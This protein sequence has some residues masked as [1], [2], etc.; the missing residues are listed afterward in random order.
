MWS[1]YN[2]GNAEGRARSS[3]ERLPTQGSRMRVLRWLLMLCLMAQT[4]C[5]LCQPGFLDDYAAVGGKWQ[6]GNPTDGRLG[7]ILSAH[8]AGGVMQGTSAVEYMPATLD[9]ATQDYPP[10][11]VGPAPPSIMEPDGL[12]EGGSGT[13]PPVEPIP[14]SQP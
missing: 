13:S 3:S 5:T 11:G 6:R 2:A 9:S 14:M 8:R 1:V 4:G 12:F 7:S 10:S